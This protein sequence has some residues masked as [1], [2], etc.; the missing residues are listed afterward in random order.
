MTNHLDRFAAGFH[1]GS[2]RA[3]TAT[4]RTIA[5]AVLLS[6]RPAPSCAGRRSKSSAGR[7]EQH[8]ASARRFS[9]PRRLVA[10]GMPAFT[11]QFGSDCPFLLR[12]SLQ[13]T[14][15]FTVL[16]DH[17]AAGR[18]RAFLRGARAFRPPVRASYANMPPVVLQHCHYNPHLCRVNFPRS[19]SP[20]HPAKTWPRSPA[21]SP[22]VPTQS[23]RAMDSTSSGRRH[24]V[25]SCGY[26]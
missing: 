16:A 22:S 18:V 19:D 14:A 21:S 3:A 7:P 13:G 15:P 23:T 1:T 20:S 2:V 8:P 24:R 10:L 6:I 26:R 11:S 12:D 9:P 25:N 5:S 4:S 17:T